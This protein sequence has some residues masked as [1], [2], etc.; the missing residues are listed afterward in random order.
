MGVVNDLPNGREIDVFVR[1]QSNIHVHNHKCSCS[2]AAALVTGLLS[3]LLFRINSIIK[4]SSKLTN[5]LSKEIADSIK[6]VRGYTHTCVIRELLINE[7]N[8]K[9]CPWRGYGDGKELFQ[10]LLNI[11]D[12][13]I[14]SKMADVLLL[15]HPNA[16]KGTKPKNPKI[17]KSF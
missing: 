9:H 8:G 16:E 12:D 2:D 15:K 11:D 13:Q 4:S 10:K 5:P 1:C 6:R 14:L 3:L 17:Q 7:S